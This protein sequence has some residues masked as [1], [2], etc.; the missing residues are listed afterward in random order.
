MSI[1]LGV[2]FKHHWYG[3]KQSK[4]KPTSNLIK[5]EYMLEKRERSDKLF[6]LSTNDSLPSLRT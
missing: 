2:A 4:Q 3:Q 1:E 5:R 6:S